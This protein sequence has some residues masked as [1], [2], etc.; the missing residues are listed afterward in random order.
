MNRIIS[1]LERNSDKT[2]LYHVQ[3]ARGLMHYGRRKYRAMRGIS[4]S[5]SDL[6]A[7]L[8][9]PFSSR[10]DIAKH[11][12]TRQS[13]RFFVKP[14]NQ[15][16]MVSEVRE[17]YPEGVKPAIEEAERIC[18]HVFDLLGSGPTEHGPRIDWHQDFKSGYRW[19]KVYYREVNYGDHEKGYDIKVP[20][21]LSRFQHLVTL[22]KAYCYTGNEK[23]AEE[24]VAQI[25]D[26]IHENPPQVGLNWQ[27]TM[28]VAIRVVNWI[29]GFY[30]FRDAPSVTNEFLISF[31]KSL[32][33]HGRHIRNNLEWNDKVTSNHYISDLVGLVWLGLLFPEFHESSEWLDYGTR[34]LLNELRK[35]VYEDGMDY[36]AS[37]SYHRLVLELY[38][39]TFLLARLNGRS[40]PQES[41]DTIYRMFDFVRG[42]IKPNRTVPQIG[43]NDSGRLQVLEKRDPLDHS[44][45]L[46]VAAVLFHDHSFKYQDL[47]FPEEAFW[48]FGEDGFSIYTDM[49]DSGKLS[50]LSSRAFKAAGIYVMR[51]GENYCIVSCGPNGQNGNGGH[52]HNDKLSFELCMGF[53]DLIVDPGTGVYTAD[54]RLRNM[55][56]STYSHNTI[57]VDGK[58]INEFDQFRLFQLPDK[59]HARMVW[60]SQDE[61]GLCFVGEHSG[62]QRLD[63]PVKHTR[64]IFFE[65]GSQLWYVNDVLE[66]PEEIPHKFELFFHF[67]LNCK[68]KKN[69]EFKGW[70]FPHLSG[71]LDI[72]SPSEEDKLYGHSFSVNLDSITAEISVASNC[73]VTADIEE[74]LI[75]PGYGIMM[76][77]PVLAVR[78][79]GPCPAYFSTLI[80]R[81]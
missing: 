50:D 16:V 72:P 70:S 79:T 55:F 42:I 45:L 30:F 78:S 25:L 37:T 73:Q 69:G 81:T 11:F 74:G 7:A 15:E 29:W 56:R 18:G 2:L 26:W 13:P 31:I 49:P 51:S 66:G 17:L 9:I 52:A 3:T 59:S 68:L 76:P 46:P 54:Y 21:E 32:L 23:Y 63:Q 71:C 65:K 1:Y 10:N 27:C 48:L 8:S 22:G 44:Y 36:E 80:R 35:Q 75:S 6:C 53:H 14:D 5:D 62:Y 12:R 20:R 43:D 33:L 28:D 60:W 57:V 40:W 4:L 47:D 38:Y 41:L 67:A 24:F 58:E 77:A 19:S 61:N 64:R 34:E 39:T